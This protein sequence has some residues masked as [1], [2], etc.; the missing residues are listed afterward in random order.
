MW[1][2]DHA[3]SLSGEELP[4]GLDFFRGGFLLSD[5]MVETKHHQR[6]GVGEHPFVERQLLAC[7]VNPLIHS[8]GMPCRLVHERL[9]PNGR[10]IEQF[11]R[12]GNSLQKLIRL[13]LYG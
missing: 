6:V 5:H 10:K 13:I 7:L 8:D 12:T 9:K 2:E 1:A 3:R 11:E 4:D